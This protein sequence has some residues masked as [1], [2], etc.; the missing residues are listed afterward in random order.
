[1]DKKFLG[2]RVSTYLTAAAAL[3]VAV[4]LWLTAKYVN[5]A[6]DLAVLPRTFFRG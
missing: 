5:T 4:V 2:I 6:I 1:M 3:A